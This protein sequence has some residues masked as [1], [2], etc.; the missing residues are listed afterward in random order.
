MSGNSS[1]ISTLVELFSAG[2]DSAV[3][4]SAPGRSDLTF[5]GLRALMQRTVARLNE[6]GIGRNDR[7]A[8]VLPNGPD[9]ASAFV[10]IA[11]APLRHRSIRG[12]GAK[13]SSSTCPT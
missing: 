9:M 4:L 7:V 3:A 10:S 11:A 12:T 5:G 2:A 8:I 6:L 1:G 13:N